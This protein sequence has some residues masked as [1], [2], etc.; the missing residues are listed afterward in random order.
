MPAVALQTD[1]GSVDLS[2]LM[3]RVGAYVERYYATA[4]RVVAVERITLQSLGMD[5]APIGF[6]RRLEYD[7]RIEWT[8]G[9]HGEPG[10][11]QVRRHLVK[12]NG[13]APR[14]KDE[15]G[16]SDPRTVSPEPLAMFLPGQQRDYVFTSFR[17]GRASGRAVTMVDYRSVKKGEMQVSWHDDCVSVELPGRSAG[18]LWADPA[19]GDVLRVDERLVGTFEVPVPPEQ[20]RTGASARLTIERSDTSIRYKPVQ[21]REPDETVLMPSEVD[22][23]TVIRDAGIP[24]MR[25]RQVFSGYRR[26]VTEGRVLED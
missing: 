12:V 16:C 17:K 20:Q 3:A 13:R 4:Q 7:L 10:A 19:T 23:L 8:P 25:I 1:P 21:F 14:P 6:P 11:A 2:G 15:P 26:F 5:L 9:A 24:R 22:T 18:R